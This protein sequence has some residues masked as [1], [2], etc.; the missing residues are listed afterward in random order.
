MKKGEF[1]NVTIHM[2]GERVG[3]GSFFRNRDDVLNGAMLLDKA[4]VLKA[5]N[6]FEAI[7]QA[8]FSFVDEKANELI[9]YY[10]YTSGT[11]DIGPYSNNAM[12]TGVTF[13]KLPEVKYVGMGYE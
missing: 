5:N 9:G 1:G 4:V 8:F 11:I 13:R 7:H 2:D 10:V 3:V 6:P 12:G